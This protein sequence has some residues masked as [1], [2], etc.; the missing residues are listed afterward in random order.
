MVRLVQAEYLRILDDSIPYTMHFVDDMVVVNRWGLTEQL[1][2]HRILSS[3]PDVIAVS[4]RCTTSTPFFVSQNTY[5][6]YLLVF[7][8]YLDQY[9]ALPVF[10]LAR[11]SYSSP[12]RPR[13]ETT[14]H[15]L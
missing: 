11:A 3:R 8:F 6:R 14:M 12:S 9:A 1:T 7:L 13:I 5:P 15:S 4:L 10:H 2:A